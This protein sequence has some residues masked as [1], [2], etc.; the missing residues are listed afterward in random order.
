M[1]TVQYVYTRLFKW[2]F[3]RFALEMSNSVQTRYGNTKFCYKIDSWYNFSKF[4]LKDE[5]ENGLKQTV[6]ISQL[7]DLKSFTIVNEIHLFLG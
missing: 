5:L 1:S 4:R 6:T 2:C 3:Q 7:P